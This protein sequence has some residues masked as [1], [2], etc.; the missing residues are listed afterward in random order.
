METQCRISVQHTLKIM[1]LL[2]VFSVTET[3]EGFIRHILR[4]T[5]YNQ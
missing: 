1:I 3:I 2:I 5:E 4:Y